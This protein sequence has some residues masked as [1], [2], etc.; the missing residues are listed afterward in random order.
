V[1][2][3]DSLNGRLLDAAVAQH[4]FG[5]E[6]EQRTNNRTRAKDVVC[7][8][9]GKQWV[10]C[11]FYAESTG[12]SLNI[13]YELRQRGWTWRRE[14]RTGSRWSQPGIGRVILEHR[15]GRSV[16]S[17]GASLNEAL[18]RAAVKAVST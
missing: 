3:V 11:A 7:R 14:E 12:A 9:A 2:N 4:L 13:E 10:R 1:E 17:E 5:L 18:C 8:Q 15:D 6:V 16:E